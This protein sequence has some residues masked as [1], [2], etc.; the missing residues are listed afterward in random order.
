MVEVFKQP[1]YRPLSV[2]KQVAII[3]AATSGALDDVE[4]KHVRQWE[5]DFLAYV[6]AQHA[7]VYEGI[8]TKRVLDD[9]LKA[10]LNAAVKTF[11]PLF[12]AE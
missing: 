5:R 4:V 1:Q 10:K 6:E 12:K 11:K 2:E 8:R 9:D 3:Y 7:G